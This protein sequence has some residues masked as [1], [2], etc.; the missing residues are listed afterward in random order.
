MMLFMKIIL[1]IYHVRL[2]EMNLKFGSLTNN[3]LGIK[4]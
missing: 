2:F 3:K 4:G 1:N